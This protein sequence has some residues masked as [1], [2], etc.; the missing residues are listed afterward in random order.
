MSS[1]KLLMIKW[2]YY[3]FCKPQKERNEILLKIALLSMQHFF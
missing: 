2:F 3:I 1:G